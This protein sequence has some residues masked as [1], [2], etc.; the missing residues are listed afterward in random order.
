MIPPD[1]ASGPPAPETLE[2]TVVDVGL[3]TRRTSAHTP[4]IDYDRE[5][6][7]SC[8]QTDETALAISIVDLS[9]P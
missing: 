5:A 8:N 7:S 6:P 3:H 2:E 1:E 4:S 9:V